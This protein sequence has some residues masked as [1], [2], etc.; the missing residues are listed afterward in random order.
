MNNEWWGDVSNYTWRARQEWL[1]D[2]SECP[3]VPWEEPNE[4]QET[5]KPPFNLKKVTWSVGSLTSLYVISTLLKVITTI[6]ME[7]STI[8]E[9]LTKQQVQQDT[10]FSSITVCPLLFISST[11]IF[12]S[13]GSRTW[14]THSFRTAAHRLTGSLDLSLHQ[15]LEDCLMRPERPNPP[16]VFWCRLAPVQ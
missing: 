5:W 10:Y 9:N 13:S 8:D 14:G 7:I 15:L 11:M 16:V 3:Q 4:I 12:S 1:R 2:N 6:R